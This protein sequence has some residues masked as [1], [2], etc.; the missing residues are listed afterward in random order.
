MKVFQGSQH[1]LS[2]FPEGKLRSLAV[3]WQE[4]NT[5]VSHLYYLKKGLSV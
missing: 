4:E 5:G 1:L 2:Q 3:Q